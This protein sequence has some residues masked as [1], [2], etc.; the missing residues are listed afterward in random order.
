M[1]IGDWRHECTNF[2]PDYPPSQYSDSIFEQGVY[3]VSTR[4]QITDIVARWPGLSHDSTIFNNS[5]IKA[6]FE[7]GYNDNV[8]LLA[9]GGC[10]TTSYTMTPLDNPRTPVEQLYDE[11]QIRTR[12]T[13]KVLWNLERRFLVLAIGLRTKLNKSP[14]IIVATAV[15]HNM[16]RQQGE[17]DPLDDP[18]LQLPALWDNFYNRVR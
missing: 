5:C 11:S 17:A 14:T 8:L 6:K 4:T 3:T 15:L 12:N 13:R 2:T 9:D 10:A 7:S 18:E 1:S 16:L